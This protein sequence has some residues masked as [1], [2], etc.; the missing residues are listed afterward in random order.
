MLADDATAE[1]ATQEVFLRVAKHLRDAPTSV[2]ALLW[3]YRIATNYCLNLLRDRKRRLS[4]GHYSADEVESDDG[5]DILANRDLARRVIARA[6]EH[7]RASA[8]LHHVDGMSHEEVGQVL[9]ISRR[10]VINH[11]AE[12]DERARKFVG[13]QA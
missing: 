4:W 5:E 6:P 9:G 1:D 7:L 11:L 3:I 8:W 2:E 10:T 13:R 12:F